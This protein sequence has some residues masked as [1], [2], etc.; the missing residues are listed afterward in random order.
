MLVGEYLEKKLVSSWDYYKIE[1]LAKKLKFTNF[2]SYQQ[3][4]TMSE[5][6]KMKIRL[7]EALLSEPTTLIIDEPT[8]HLD[9]EGIMWFEEYIRHL[10]KT[11]VMISHDRSFLNHT[12]DEIWEIDKEQIFRFVGDYD[13][14]REE[15][16]S[17]IDK[18]DQEYV[19]FLKKKLNT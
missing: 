4:S 11:V 5:G 13:N 3:I 14:Y 15:K 2:D 16:L 8:N 1:T 12:V 7:I 19:L 6:Q 9:I 17:L 18:W 10:D